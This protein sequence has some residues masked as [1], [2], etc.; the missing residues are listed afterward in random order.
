MEMV[1]EEK[2]M[3]DISK[4]LPD[5]E[6]N[7]MKVIWNLASPITTN[8]ITNKLADNTWKPQTLLTVLKRLSEKGFLNIIKDGKEHQ[9]EVL[10]KEDEY[11]EIETGSFLKRYSGNSIGALVKTLYSEGDLTDDDINELRDILEQKE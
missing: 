9:Y 1:E 4:R 8:K 6:F 11:L 3:K 5:A 7:V 2:D 10:I